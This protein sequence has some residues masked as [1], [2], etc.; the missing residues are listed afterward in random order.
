M[1]ARLTHKTVIQLNLMAESCTICSSQSRRPVWK[2]LDTPSH[3]D[4]VLIHKHI[5]VSPFWAFF[6]QSEKWRLQHR[7][8]TPTS[9]IFLDEIASGRPLL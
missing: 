6:I 8:N 9:H 5:L 4:S 3:L 1:A 7:H 2:L